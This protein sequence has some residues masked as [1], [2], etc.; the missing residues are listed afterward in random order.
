MMLSALILPILM[1][2]PAHAWRHTKK[3]WDRNADF[4]FKWYMSDS[5]EDSWS[6]AESA[7]LDVLKKAWDHWSDEAPCAE[8]STNYQGERPGHNAGYTNDSYN[9]VYFDDPADELGVGILAAALTLTSGNVAFSLGGET[10][11]YAFDS[12]IIFNDDLVWFSDEQIRAGECSGGWSLEGVATHEIGHTLGMGHSCEEGEACNDLALRYATMF[13]SGDDCS[14]NQS[15]LKSDDIEGV[16]ALYGPY[17]AFTSDS[18]RNGGVPLEV[19]F[20]V[21]MDDT[22]ENIQITWNFGDGTIEEN[23]DTSVCHTYDVAGQHSV[24][25]SVTGTAEECGEWNSTQRE[26][27]FVTVCEPPAPAEDLDGLFTYEDV[28][29]TLF[30]MINQVDTSVYGCI[31][32]IR[33]DVFKV[34]EDTPMQSISAWSPKIDFKEAGEYRVVLNVGAP[35][36]L[37]SAEELLI[38]VDDAGGCSTAPAFGGLVGLLLGLFGLLYRRRD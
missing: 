10:Y 27:A 18:K 1:A 24:S 17:A 2:E 21:E 23:N 14:E 12:D 22:N 25:M 5:F 26:L 28:D 34:G 32:R 31:E 29:G 30:Q 11:T 16:T 37:F 9:T 15:E 38:K 33:W 8:I 3:V 13:W 6:D 7:E 35:G 20:D 36:D 4:P 19:C